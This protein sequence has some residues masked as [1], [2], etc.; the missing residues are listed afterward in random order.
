MSTYLIHNIVT[1]FRTDTF[2][3]LTNGLFLHEYM[4]KKHNWTMETYKEYLSVY[5][6][7]LVGDK[8]EEE[9]LQK[10]EQGLMV[11]L[12]PCLN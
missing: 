3:A 8:P 6:S 1:I 12:N 2:L 5:I 11:M 4:M 7:S 10:M 9:E